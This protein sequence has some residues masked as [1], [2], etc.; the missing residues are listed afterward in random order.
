MGTRNNH[1]IAT[2]VKFPALSWQTKEKADPESKD[3]VNLQ[4]IR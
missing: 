2:E 1:N 4:L 3:F